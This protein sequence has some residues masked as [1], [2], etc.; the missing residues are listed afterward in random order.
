MKQR[1]RKKTEKIAKKRREAHKEGG[2]ECGR[3]RQTEGLKQKR[4]KKVDKN[5]E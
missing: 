4:D 3:Q 5:I 2:T 1:K